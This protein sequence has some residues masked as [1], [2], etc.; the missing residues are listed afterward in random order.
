MIGGCVWVSR[1]QLLDLGSQSRQ[2]LAGRAGQFN[3][4]GD[5]RIQFGVSD[6]QPWIG[7]QAIKQVIIS[8][9]GFSHL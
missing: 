4:I 3:R 9:T 8:P 7:S 5:G 1:G 6:T 2:L